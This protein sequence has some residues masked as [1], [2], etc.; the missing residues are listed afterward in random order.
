MR[1]LVVGIA[2]GIM[3]VDGD[4]IYEVQDLRVGLF[5]DGQQPVSA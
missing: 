4:T 5:R 2:D 3:K 1:K